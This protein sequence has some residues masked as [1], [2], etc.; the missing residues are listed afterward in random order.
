MKYTKENPGSK[1]CRLHFETRGYVA[2]A[3]TFGYELDVTRIPKEDRD[4]ISGQ[5]EM[6]HKYNE[7]VRTGDYYRISSYR[8][9]GV[10]DSWMYVSKD[11]SKALVTYIKVMSR[12]NRRSVIL[13][14]RGLDPKKL[15]SVSSDKDV[16]CL[17]ERGDILL[18][19]ETLINAGILIDENCSDMKGDFSGVLIEVTEAGNDRV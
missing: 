10:N 18:Y 13:K 9:N 5:V 8:E 12:P 15:Y 6:Y 17:K 1:D 11:K 16:L 3:G 2:L 7:L 4:M 14:L 19:G